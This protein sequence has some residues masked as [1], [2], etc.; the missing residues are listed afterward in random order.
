MPI[1]KMSEIYAD[2]SEKQYIVGAFN[3]FNLDTM[4]A[5][6]QAA[7]KE[8][9]PVILQVS[10]GAR[11]YIPSLELFISIMKIMADTVTVPVSINHDHCLGIQAAKE[12]IDAGVNSVMFDG[13]HLS[14]EEN[15]SAT[16]EVVE[17]A[18]EKGVCVEAELGCLP[19]FE[20]EVF[21]ENAVFTNPEM[22]K[23][24]V[25]RTGC[26]FLA[27]A[28]GTSH[29][30]VKSDN[31]LLLH[32]DILEKIHEIIPRVPLVLHGAA[33]LPDEL[34]TYVNRY[35]GKVP[36]LKNCSEAD[37]NKS[38]FYG[39]CKANMDVDNFLAYTGTVRKVLTEKPE[40]YDPRIY[41]KP[42]KEAF[43]EEIRHKMKLVNQ[44]SNHNWLKEQGEKNDTLN[45]S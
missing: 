21:A 41:L 17:Y 5:V 2:A 29:G 37:I 22:A 42:A 11:K 45:L 30:G 15:I 38:R 1:V 43:E 33:S 6:L 44:S 27:V 16:R 39:I 13:S 18:K 9:S 34:I 31:P 7:E 3:V 36:N 26:D 25:E 8:E 32:F 12:A 23:E 10:M 28:V 40:K 24:F 4:H 20:D 14:F 35:G 19:G